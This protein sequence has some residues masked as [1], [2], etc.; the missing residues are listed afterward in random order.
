MTDMKNGNAGDFGSGSD[1]S[2]M[3][4]EMRF[5]QSM[6]VIMCSMTHDAHDYPHTLIKSHFMYTLC[7]SNVIQINDLLVLIMVF[8]VYI[9]GGFKRQ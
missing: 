7:A 3:E 5:S 4:D 8:F 9:L 1:N 2:R 6:S